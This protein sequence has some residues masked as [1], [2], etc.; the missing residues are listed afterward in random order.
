MTSLSFA[1]HLKMEVFIPSLISYCL[2]Q[3]KHSKMIPNVIIFLFLPCP[4]LLMVH[5]LTLKS[6]RLKIRA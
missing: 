4:E 6:H 1:L 3:Y 2:D 5:H